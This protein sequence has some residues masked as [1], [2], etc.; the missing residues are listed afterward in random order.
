MKTMTK[1]GRN[2]RFV[3]PSSHR[4]ALG[5]EEGDDL[6]VILEDKEIRVFTVEQ[7]IKKAQEIVRRR[8][9]AGRMLS[10]ELIRERRE[11]AKRE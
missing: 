5:L 6:I 3:I 1:L 4:K 7:G 8:V 11:E 2:G 9:P 10:E